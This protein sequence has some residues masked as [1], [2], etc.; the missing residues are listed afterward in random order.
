MSSDADRSRVQRAALRVGLL[1]SAASAL[2]VAGGVGILIAVL[3]SS[4]R[5]DGH[6][7]GDEGRGEGGHGLGAPDGD[8]FVVD[9]DHILPWV[10][11]L[12]ILGVLLLGVVAWVAARRAVHPLAEALRAQRAFVSDASHELRT[13]LTTLT[14]R[15]QILERR[16]SRGEPIDDTITELRRDARVLDEVLTDMLLT[17]EGTAT[18]GD[19]CVVSE[20]VEAARRTIEPLAAEAGVTV[21]A[22]TPDGLFA[23]LPAVTLTRLCVALLDNAV[24]HAPAGSEVTIDARADT[25]GVAVRVSDAGPGIAPADADRIFERFARAG[26]A[27]RRRGFG[28]GL[29]LVREAAQRHGGS[30]RIESTSARGTTFL[31]RLPGA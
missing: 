8:R 5:P 15:I 30:I 2:I 7:D 3:V 24:Q 19:R 20:A 29:A 9:L 1:V 4:A 23:A 25:G 17:A 31:L 22:E 26:E 21:R 14:S 27:G 6:P 12:G 13:P 11:G 28:L 10:I 16:R 18:P